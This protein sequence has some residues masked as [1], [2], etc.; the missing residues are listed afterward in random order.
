MR[1]IV[2]TL[3][4]LFAV[5]A[6]GQMAEKPDT[7]HYGRIPVAFAYS[8][9]EKDTLFISEQH[10]MGR[11]LYYVWMKDPNYKGDNPVI[12]KT[13]GAYINRR[14]MTDKPTNL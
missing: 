8:T 5:T 3:L 13:S 4:L 7:T 6:Y 1:K 9:I 2:V 11:Y 12:V 14:W 10:S